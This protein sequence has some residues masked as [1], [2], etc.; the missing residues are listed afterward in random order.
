M[1]EDTRNFLSTHSNKGFVD[2]ILNKEDYPVLDNE[3]GATARDYWTNPDK[4]KSISTHSMAAEVTED[5][6]NI[7]FP[8]VMMM[9]DEMVR[10]PFRQA[11]K[12]AEDSGQF[13]EFGNLNEAI[14]FAK[15]Y[16]KAWDK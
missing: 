4:Y 1:S 16:K 9:N 11:Q 15:N 13:I 14:D 3:T 8:T 10:L 6:R 12:L 2:R 7:V 5:G